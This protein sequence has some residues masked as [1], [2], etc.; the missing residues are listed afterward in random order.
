MRNSIFVL[1]ILFFVTLLGAD[2][3][4]FT[5]PWYLQSFYDYYSDNYI[6]TAN[7]GRGY[8][9]TSV[10]GNIE[11][12]HLNPAAFKTESDYMYSEFLVKTPINDMNTATEKEFVSNGFL[13]MLGVSKHFGSHWDLGVSYSGVKS[14]EFDR[15]SIVLMQEP[16][17]FENRFPSI[18]DYVLTLTG[19]YK[20]NDFSFG[21]N[22]LNHF[23]TLKD[24][25]VYGRN[26]FARNDINT[27]AFRVQ[28]GVY[29]KKG[30]FAMGASYIPAT[31]ATFESNI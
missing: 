25:V 30:V 15:I 14:M 11:N 23:Y 3:I 1:I 22:V 17:N 6:G 18:S 27:Y 21:L 16:G 12:I 5:S 26:Q 19:S 2:P 29:W 10:M 31:D 24:N 20:W 9:G 28:P 4:D 8:T 13:G 7:I